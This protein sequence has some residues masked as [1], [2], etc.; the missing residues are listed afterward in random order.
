MASILADQINEKMFD[1]IGDDV[2]EFDNHD[3]PQIIEDYQDDLEKIFLK[4][5]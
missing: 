4:K 5:E 1:V 3:Q 2:I